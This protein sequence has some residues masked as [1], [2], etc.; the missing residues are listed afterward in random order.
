MQKNKIEAFIRNSVRDWVSS[1]SERA[2]LD[3]IVDI[4]CAD[5]PTEIRKFHEEIYNNVA[6]T[7]GAITSMLLNE[8]VNDVDIYFTDD[9]IA[10]KVARYYL[11][12]LVNDGKLLPS[13]KVD[14]ITVLPHE[15][16][17]KIWIQSQGVSGEEVSK[18]SEY[19]YFEGQAFEPIADFFD[20]GHHGKVQRKDYDVQYITDN[21]IT[22]F[23]GIQM[24]FRFTGPIEE[25]HQY[26]DFVHCTNYWT[27]KTGLVY[28]LDALQSI[29]EKRLRYVGSKYPVAALFRLRKFIQRGWCISAGE[30]VKMAYDISKLDLDNPSVMMDQCI[31][32][33]YAY[34]SE[35]LTKLEQR[36]DID[37][38]YLFTL[39]DEVFSEAEN[40]EGCDPHG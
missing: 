3:G 12:K 22:L 27:A 6:V 28:N 20:L 30:L 40:L 7:G 5:Y 25:V 23:G 35:F 19:D 38:T 14:K 1:I 16:G 4:H 17:V 34:F 2:A 31:G 13:K 21:A 32:C 24:I 33:D 26:F 8:E 18:T 15:L 36:Q 37:R 9:E 11:N 10:C 39:L 29:L